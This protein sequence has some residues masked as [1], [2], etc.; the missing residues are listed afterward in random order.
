MRLAEHAERTEKKSN[1]CRILAGKPER[2]IPLRRRRCRWADN[3]KVDLRIIGWGGMDWIDLAEDRDQRRAVVYT[4]LK[5]RVPQNV[6][7]FLSSCTTGGFSKSA[8]LRGV[9]YEVC[10]LGQPPYHRNTQLHAY[11]TTSRVSGW[12]RTP[13]LED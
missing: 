3:I 11:P 4:A 8:Q 12:V 9:S 5:L 10:V 1:A 13:R 7:K 6:V 2:K